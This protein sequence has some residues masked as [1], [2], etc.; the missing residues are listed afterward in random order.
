MH[1]RGGAGGRDGLAVGVGAGHNGGDINAD[2]GVDGARGDGH[3]GGHV[4]GDG[5][6]GGDARV[7]GNVGSAETLDVDDSLGDDLVG[8]TVSEDAVEDARDEDFVGAVARRVGVV[9][10]ANLEQEGVQA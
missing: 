5:G 4:A 10:A 7:L 3:G 8:L 1:D 9:R 6:T 2:G